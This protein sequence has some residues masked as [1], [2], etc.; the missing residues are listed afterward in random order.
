MPH[1]YIRFKTSLGAQESLCKLKK[2]AFFTNIIDSLGHVIR[3]NIVEIVSHTTGN[4][5]E[6]KTSMNLTELQ[7]FPILCNLVRMFL[8]DYARVAEPPN[9]IF[10]KDQPKKFG[11]MNAE[12]S[13]ALKELQ[14]GLSLPPFRF[15]MYIQWHHAQYGRV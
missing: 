13:T 2:N 6:L 7:S 4:I 12:K 10:Q 8:P 1:D 9:R 11:S 14:S 3:P 15:S 5:K